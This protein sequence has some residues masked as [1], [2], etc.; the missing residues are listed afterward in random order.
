[1]HVHARIRGEGTLIS[2]EKHY[3]ISVIFTQQMEHLF[4]ELI[5]VELLPVQT[6]EPRA[7]VTHL[8]IKSF[9]VSFQAKNKG[10]AASKHSDP[11]IKSPSRS[12]WELPPP[13]HFM[14]ARAAVIT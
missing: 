4:Q 7:D 10:F 1:M 9:F 2:V 6:K 13:G 14:Q 11:L 3:K 8:V 5:K 12:C